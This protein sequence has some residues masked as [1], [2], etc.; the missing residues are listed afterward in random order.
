MK[1]ISTVRDDAR[2]LSY[3]VTFARSIDGSIP[4]WERENRRGTE[5]YQNGSDE[6]SNLR[7]EDKASGQRVSR[8]WDRNDDDSTT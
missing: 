5:L 2:F 7:G 8:G 4:V 1:T 6:D 3:F